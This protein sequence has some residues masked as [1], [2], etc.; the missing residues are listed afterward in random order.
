MKKTIKIL[1]IATLLLMASL[2]TSSTSQFKTK[3]NMD[4]KLEKLQ[5]CK[6]IYYNTTENI[7][8]ACTNCYNITIVDYGNETCLYQWNE[9]SNNTDYCITE[10]CYDYDCVIETKIT[11]NKKSE[12]VDKGKA[13]IKLTNKEAK[14]TNWVC[15]YP[16]YNCEVNNDLIV[17]DS[18]RDGNGDGICQSGER[19][20]T[21]EI[22]NNLTLKKN[23]E[24][25][26][27]AEGFKDN[28]N[29]FDIT[30]QQ[31]LLELTQ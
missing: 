24:F 8:G 23:I 31:E 28:F 5:D 6:D 4:V 18:K 11:E 14:T 9:T 7:I 26:R 10:K 17:C 3:D 25:E 30:C 1:M 27:Q 13:N 16:D 12:C 15:D 22:G 29:E 2:L 19:C 21:F 20:F